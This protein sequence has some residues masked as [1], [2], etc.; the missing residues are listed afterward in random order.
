[1]IGLRSNF[2]NSL[3]LAGTI[4]LLTGA[5][6]F[7]VARR[8]LTDGRPWPA[9]TARILTVGSILVTIAATALPTRF[10][11]AA[12]WERRRPRARMVPVERELR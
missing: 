8:Q 1:M 10:G 6:A 4:F 11:L 7:M 3:V 5:A 9:P 12:E 2:G